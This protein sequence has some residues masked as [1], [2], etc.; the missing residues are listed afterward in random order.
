MVAYTSPD[1]LPYFECTDSPCLNTG[2]VCDPSTV[3][4]DL[5]TELDLILTGFGSTQSRT[6]DGIPLA[7]VANNG[8]V[9]DLTTTTTTFPV[10]WDSVLADNDNMV[11]LDADNLYVKINRPGIWWIELYLE[12]TPDISNDN[13]LTG[14]LLQRGPTTG[15]VPGLPLTESTSR[16][17]QSA[18]GFFPGFVEV[19]AAYAF[20][21]TAAS[22]A[23][24]STIDIGA[25]V[26]A[27]GAI[28]ATTP[29]LTVRYAEM[30]VYWTSEAT[31]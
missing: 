29:Q 23:L 26:Q 7:K 20:Q 10:V 24:S 25:A 8:Q 15:N 31:P 17:R 1:C 14:H 28:S 19:R 27:S 30:T 18:L 21:V 22:L 13:E 6:A 3:W 12:G 9:E 4:C 5:V 2:T 11:N 16:F